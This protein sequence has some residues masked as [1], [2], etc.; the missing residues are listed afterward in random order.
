MSDK[1]EGRATPHS[2]IAFLSNNKEDVIE[3]LMKQYGEELKRIIFM[4]VKNWSQADD[5]IQDVFVTIFIK[6]DTYK[7]KSSLKNWI[8]SIAI[9][10]CK[11]YLR[12]W[13]YKKMMFA[14]V[15]PSIKVDD[16]AINYVDKNTLDSADFL[17]VVK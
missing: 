11:D 17:S 9:N 4:Y 2:D 10:K 13:Q 15:A 1:Q 16:F 8:Y 6:L 12:S 3:M 5:L 7:G 14:D